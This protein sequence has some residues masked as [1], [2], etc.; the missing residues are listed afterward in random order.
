MSPGAIAADGSGSIFVADTGNYRIQKFDNMG[1][2]LTKWGSVGTG[3]EQFVTMGGVAVDSSGKVF[4]TDTAFGFDLSVALMRI[5]EFT[6][7][8]TF[9]GTIG[10]AGI[11]EGQLN[12]PTELAMGVNGNLFVAD[13]WNYR[14]QKFA[15]H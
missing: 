8:G 15:C 11:G 6:S 14:V 4:V 13:T 1:T 7:T 5:K 9:L 12:V 2:F 10:C 3:D